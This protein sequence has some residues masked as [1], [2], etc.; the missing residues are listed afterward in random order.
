MRE[1]PPSEPRCQYSQQSKIL[2]AS[3]NLI[4]SPPL[5]LECYQMMRVQ[6]RTLFYWKMV[7]I[8]DTDVIAWK[9]VNDKYPSYFVAYEAREPGAWRVCSMVP[10]KFECSVLGTAGADCC[11][12][13]MPCV[14]SGTNTMCQCNA[15]PPRYVLC[16]CKSSSN[17]GVRPRRLTSGT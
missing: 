11:V 17:P 5:M 7:S 16:A 1:H 2:G 9:A 10:I 14:Y 4:K 12:Q 6:V 3:I 13:D 8:L 15:D